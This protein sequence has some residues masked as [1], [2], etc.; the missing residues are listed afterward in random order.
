MED[1]I[2][3]KIKDRIDVVEVIGSYIKLQKA[4]QN[5]KALCPF[6]SEKT[7]SFFVSP[8]KQVWKCFGCGKGGD[9]FTFIQEIEG[10]DFGDAL[11]MLARKAGVELESFNPE[12]KTERTRLYEI[13]ELSA[14]F[15]E[16]QLK[17]SVAGKRAKE[18]L[19]KRGVKEETIKKWR[20][21]Y[22]PN[23]WRALSDFLVSKGYNRSEAV[24]VGLAI[25]PENEKAPYDRF[26]GRIIFPIFDI[27][28][29]VIGFGGRILE[30][31]ENKEA[32]KYINTPN[33]M[34]YDKSRILY[35]LNFA[36][37]EIRKKDFVILVEGYMDVILSQQAGVGNTVA[38][39]GTALTPYQLKIL[40]R[41]TSNIYFSFDVDSAGNMAT[42]RGIDLAQAQD[43]NIKIVPISGGKDPADIVLKSKDEWLKMIGGSIGAMDFYFNKAVS[44]FDSK[45]EEGKKG[46][47]KMILPKIKNI[48][49]K[50]IQAHWIQ[51]LSDKIKIRED[52]I[53]QEMKSAVPS[54]KDINLGREN[55]ES[56]EESKPKLK[57]REELLEER[58]IALSL[59]FPKESDLQGTISEDD[60]AFFSDWAKK[61][62]KEIRGKNFLNKEEANKWLNG[63]GNKEKQKALLEISILADNF[64]E[65]TE[66][67]V[68]EDISTCLSELKKIRVKKEMEE[69]SQKIKDAE[70]E[71]DSKKV[72]ELT[73]KFNNLSKKLNF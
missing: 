13:V 19:A 40:K 59:A 34:L 29:Q 65:L 54:Q 16:K 38:S 33:T 10:V 25:K 72:L 69:I 41:Y 55:A 1:P 51:K 62:I 45:S 49:N 17:E 32:A 56:G 27:N 52:I 66:K 4:G 15:F 67:E 21:G 18:Y 60:F 53:W 30:N 14:K 28:S 48:P 2:V 64:S 22:A 12:L 44:N 47:S 8:S 3:Q 37:T 63:I 50:I 6:H 73:E 39:S 46:I 20:L 71:G 43:F 11:R 70:K 26:R 35:G 61:T 24:K 23:E 31:S 42:D 57:P 68:R 7:P 5:Y 9:A 58:I 36:K